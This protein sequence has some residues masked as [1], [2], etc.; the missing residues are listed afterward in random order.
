VTVCRD[1]CVFCASV[2][3]SLLDVTVASAAALLVG[4]AGAVRSAGAV[5]GITG[6]SNLLALA[7]LGAVLVSTALT[8]L[9]GADGVATTTNVSTG[10]DEEI[11][12]E[13]EGTQQSQGENKVFHLETL[14][15]KVARRGVEPL[16]SG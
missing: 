7:T 10:W 5:I 13:C 2:V 6:T 11:K 9:T 12:T 4:R 8:G 16:S 15:E 14:V 1:F 3:V